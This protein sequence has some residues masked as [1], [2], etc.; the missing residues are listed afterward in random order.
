MAMGVYPYIT[1]SIIIQ[2]LLPI[3]PAL[4]EIAKEG[5]ADETK[6][7]ST[8]TGSPFRWRRC[9]PMDRPVTVPR[10][11]GPGRSLVEFRL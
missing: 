1:A 4:E 10:R 5:E 7:I 11:R 2:L 6:S 8:P 9:R 3:I